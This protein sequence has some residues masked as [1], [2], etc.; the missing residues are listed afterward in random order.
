MFKKCCL[1]PVER[2]GMEVTQIFQK[3]VIDEKDELFSM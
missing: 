3:L 2:L 1:Q